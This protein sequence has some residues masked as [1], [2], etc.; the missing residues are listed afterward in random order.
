MAATTIERTNVTWNPVT[1]CG[2]VPAGCERCYAL[3]L[4]R[5]LKA[6]GLARYQADRNPAAGGPGSAR[7][8]HPGML[9]V[10]LRRCRASVTDDG[11]RSS[12]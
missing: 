7:I 1:G 8:L 11:D 12:R 5:R 3:T 10:P 2:R 4:A 9:G 6:P